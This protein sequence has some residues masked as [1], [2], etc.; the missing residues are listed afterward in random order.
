MD[1]IKRQVFGGVPY[2]RSIRYNV[3]LTPSVAAREGYMETD[4]NSRIYAKKGIVGGSILVPDAKFDMLYCHG[5]AQDLMHT[6]S[7]DGTP[8]KTYE[9]LSRMAGGL[10]CN[11]TFVEYPGY[12]SSAQEPS[13]QGCVN[14][15]WE[16]L[17]AMVVD[18]SALER[19]LVLCG[20]SLGSSVA[21]QCA[22]KLSVDP[23]FTS[24]M[25]RVRLLLISPFESAICTVVNRWITNSLLWPIDMFRTDT[26]HQIT[27]PVYIIHGE[28]DKVVPTSESSSILSKMTGSAVKHVRVVRGLNH[29]V[30]VGDKFDITMGELETY[31]ETYVLMPF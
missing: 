16:F 4:I 14:A 8:V 2:L 29:E 20:Y 6:L 1:M 7:N 13:E 10:S 23:L 24:H 19:P 26:I 31:C 22:A 18:E 9:L 3:D 25:S 28:Q 12:Q 5:N 11:I 17:A 30:F 15:A 27:M 21:M